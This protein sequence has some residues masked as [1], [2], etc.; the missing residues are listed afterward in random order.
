M[1]ERIGYTSAVTF[2]IGGGVTAIF[3]GILLLERLFPQFA[4]PS[5]FHLGAF[6]FGLL[7]LI[8]LLLAGMFA[9]TTAWLVVM[10]RWYSR[11]ELAPFF[12]QPD[13]VLVTPVLTW[14]FERLYR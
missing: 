10:G 11:R 4:Q 5:E 3:L 6:L 8:I 12:T 13:I 2:I 7:L 1:R 14:L 9:G